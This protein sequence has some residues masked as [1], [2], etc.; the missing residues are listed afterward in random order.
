[1]S[2]VWGGGLFASI[3]LG[4]LLLAGAYSIPYSWIEPNVV[5]AL[6]QV[7]GEGT[8][9]E[10]YVD[11]KQFDNFTVRIMLQ[12]S[13]G[14]DDE[15]PMLSALETNRYYRYW[16]GYVVLLRPLLVF[17]S[18]NRIRA[19]FQFLLLIAITVFV[20]SAVAKW[21]R[22]G[23]APAI[24]VSAAYFMFGAP[25]AAAC[26]PF[27]PSLIVSVILSIWVMSLGKVS[28]LKLAYGF[29]LCGIAVVYLDFLDTPSVALTVP[30]G[31]LIWR[32]AVDGQ[33]AAVVLTY[34]AACSAAWAIGYFGMWAGKWLLSSVVLNVNVVADAFHQASLRAG[35][36]ESE[37]AANADAISAI[38]K[39]MGASAGVSFLNVAQAFVCAVLA[40][41]Q[42]LKGDRRRSGILLVFLICAALPYAWY[43]VLSD[44]SV[45]HWWFTYRSQLGSAAALGLAL[46]YYVEGYRWKAFQR[47]K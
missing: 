45:I 34:A 9:P 29:M 12:V 2:F 15:S 35:M 5:A 31:L 30:L 20:A 32:L 1:M 8:Y 19:L 6:H 4:W 43:A 14:G 38:S 13:A 46:S 3:V 25:Q 23:V 37:S 40:F 44:H 21:G 18:L 10:S 36:I 11:N 47:N 41:L 24:I 39:N 27:F 17:L 22:R 7:E 16:H 42:V 26:L 33:N 28:R